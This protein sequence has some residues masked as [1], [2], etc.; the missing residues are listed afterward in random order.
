MSNAAI[1]AA[2]AK[3]SRDR[4]K[5]E[6]AAELV[7]ARVRKAAD[8]R[9]VK[10]HTSCRAKDVRSF[11][12]KII[13][14]GYADPWNDVTDKAGVRVVAEIPGDIDLLVTAIDEEFGEDIVSIEDKRASL[15]PSTLGYTGVHIQVVADHGSEPSGR[16]ECEIQ[17]R[18]NAQDAW[19]IVSHR[20]LYKPTMDLPV[21]LQRAVYRLSALVELFDEEVQRVVDSLPELPGAEVADLI[22]AAEGEFLSVAHSPSNR[23]LSFLVVQ[24]IRDSITEDERGEY[25]AVLH[26]FVEA[27]RAK[28][29]NL[30]R[31]YGPHSAVSYVPDYLLFGQAE[32]LILL[33]R[34]SAKPHR[35]AAT[36][37]ASGLPWGYLQALADAAGQPLP[38]DPDEV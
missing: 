27:E 23:A 2:V 4:S 19:S 24:A 17:V 33:E 7:Q 11:H 30:F 6:E 36:W 21:R 9:R 20:L 22:E 8:A 5:F 18:T 37:R 31:E 28:L 38:D 34:M 25:N 26:A 16:I 35:L 10:C 14:K 3:F 12:K 1:A 32:S 29:E 15:D 13:V